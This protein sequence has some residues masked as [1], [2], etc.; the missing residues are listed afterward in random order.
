MTIGV[1]PYCDYSA[2]FQYHGLLDI[3]QTR[4]ILQRGTTSVAF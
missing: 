4:C 1:P 3:E 2:E